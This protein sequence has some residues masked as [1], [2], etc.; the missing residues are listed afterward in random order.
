M[1]KT[2]KIAVD[3]FSSCGKSTLAKQLANYFGFVY[4]DSGAMYRA[5][6]LF[7]LK[8]NL[9][10]NGNLKIDE[11]L[12]LLPKIDITFTNDANKGLETWLNGEN[13]EEEIRKLE[14]SSKVSVVSA[15]P[16]VRK[17][18]VELQREMSLN[19]SVVMDGRD[20]GTVVFQDADVK[21]FVTASTDIR[22]MRRYNEIKEKGLEV[23]YNDILKNITERDNLDQSRKD[24]PLK[25]ADDAVLIDN[26]KLSREEQLVL[27]IKIIS[28]KIDENRN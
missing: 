1:S 5:V 26:S 13:V 25:K 21:L 23:N 10:E 14:V 16:Q 28:E 27:A 4:V 8:N 20:I 6:T 18:M 9:F 24:S 7:S 17:R 15:I 12:I 3:G 11:L 2:I 22:A 19:K